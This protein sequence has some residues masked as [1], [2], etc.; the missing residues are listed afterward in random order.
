MKTNLESIK[1]ELNQFKKSWMYEEL[2]ENPENKMGL[3]IHFTKEQFDELLTILN[4]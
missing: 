4:K 3:M 1:N 2:T